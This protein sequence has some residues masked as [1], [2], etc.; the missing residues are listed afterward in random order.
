MGPIYSLVVSEPLR[1][2]GILTY[3]SRRPSERRLRMLM[4]GHPIIPSQLVRSWPERARFALRR[5]IRRFSEA[6]QF[7]DL[8]REHR[9]HCWCG[10][11]LGP[12]EWHRSYGV[13]QECGTYVNRRPLRP[14]QLNRLYSFDLYWHQ[15]QQSKGYPTIE[16][17]SAH[18]RSDGRVDYWLKLIEQYGPGSGRVIE[19]GC[20]HGVLLTELH[21][22][23]FDG[24]GVEPDEQTARWAR[25]SLNLDIR[26]GLFPSVELPSCNLFLAFDVLEHSHAPLEF[27]RRIAELLLPNGIAIL[28]TPVDRYDFCPPFGE[29]FEAA[30]DDLE[31]LYL[32]TDKS[33]CKLAQASGLEVVSLKERLWLH[34]E[35]CILRKG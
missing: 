13:C 25:E 15:R 29:R 24:I 10:G 28:Q 23:G 17:R 19:V 8:E 22:H 33:I 11:R 27:F 18:D 14:D 20:A 35:I 30:F 4:F 34:H 16:H 6:K 21:N 32:F 26:S 31:H 3:P 2:N 1:S 9:D 5:Y 7:R 12:F